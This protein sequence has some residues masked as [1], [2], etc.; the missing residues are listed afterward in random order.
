MFCGNCGTENVNGSKFCKGCGKELSNGQVSKKMVTKTSG[1]TM[2]T[3]N[4]DGS[5]NGAMFLESVK[6]LPKTVLIGVAAALVVLIAIIC[7]AVKAGSTINLNKYVVIETEGY[8]GFGTASAQIDWN[9]I[10]TKYGSKVKY[11]AGAKNEYGGFLSMMTPIDC[12]KECIHVEL[13]SNSNLANGDELNYTW[14][15]ADELT[16]VVKCKVKYK[17]DKYKVSGLTEVQK[18]DAFANLDVTFEGISSNGNMRYSY[19][20]TDLNNNDFHCDKANGLSNGDTVKIWINENQLE[21]YAQRF[22]KVPEQLEKEYTVEGLSSY[23]TQLAE[24]DDAALNLMQQ[25]A[26]DV[27]NAHIAQRW[28]GEGESLQ[29]FTYLGNYLLTAKNEDVWG[30]KN[31]LYLVYKAQVKNEYTNKGK[32]YNEVND[33]YWYISFSD[34]MVGG[35]G[36]VTVDVTNYDTTY[37]Q[38]KIDS[39]V[40]TGW[41]STKSWYYYGYESLDE[42]YKDVVTKNL[43]SYNHED[44]VDGTTSVSDVEDNDDTIIENS[45]YMLPGS[46]EQK[47]SKDDLEGFSEEDC[48]IA[49][50]EI[51]A[52][53]GRKF[54]DE[55]LQ[56]YFDSK[57][58]YEGT[59][60]PDDFQESE[61]SDIEIANKDTIVE[62]EKEKGYR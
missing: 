57:E 19:S 52:R 18:F 61:L 13:S 41:F 27:Y 46:G 7:I 60:D 26:T 31:I 16:Q 15:V 62:F 59:I 30:N 45:D 23:V 53:H 1:A 9:A 24:I 47:I 21:S 48:K 4:S 44:C 56:S 42:L 40:S 54:K 50:N 39:D 3:G 22:G 29:S 2:A 51:Y 43:D 10:E 28:D 11:K 37:H 33:I 49:R 12:M 32:S 6:S 38:F 58:W 36:V 14:E 5:A 8:D 17:D 25:Q 20:G 35:D 34:L 55:D